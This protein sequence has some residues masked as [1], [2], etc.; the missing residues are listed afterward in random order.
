MQIYVG[1][2]LSNISEDDLRKVF[3]KYGK[4]T[5]IQIIPGKLNNLGKEY[6]YVEMPLQAEAE[7][8]INKLNKTML[9]G[10]TLQVNIARTGLRDRRKSGRKGGRRYYDIKEDIQTNS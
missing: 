2:I 5:S 3:E 9:L 4:V 6:G 8:A 10:N 1:N 7:F